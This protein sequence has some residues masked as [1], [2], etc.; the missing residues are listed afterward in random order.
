MEFSDFPWLSYLL[1]FPIIG[2]IWS[3]SFRNTPNAPRLVALCTTLF[4]LIISLV[5]FVKTGS[6]SGYSL[7]EEYVWAPEL[8]ISLLLGVDGLSSPLILLTGIIGPL[9][10]IFAWEEKERAGLFF[11]LLLVMQTALYGVF[12]TLDYFVFYVFWEIVLIPMFF[13]IAIWGGENRRYASIKFFIYT[14]TASVI[15][16]VG[17]MALYFE[18]GVQSFSMIDIAHSSRDFTEDF[19][20]WVFAA[21][22]IGF[23]VKIPSFPWHTWLPDAHVQAPT[24]GSILLAGVMLKMGLYGLIRAALP[25]LPLGAAYFVPLMVVLAIISILYGAAL[26]LGQTDLKKLVAYSSVSHMGVALLGVATMTELGLAGAVFMMFAHGILSPAMFMIA[27]VLLHQVGTREIPKLGGLARHQP[28]TTGIFV[29][30]FMGSLGLPGMAVFV[31]ELAVFIAFFQSH[32]YWLLL[33]I[34]GMVL[35]AGYHLW[36]LQRAVFGTDSKE[37]EM[38]KVH[39]APWYELYPMFTII[40]IAA[41]FGIFPHYLMDPINTACYDILRFMGVL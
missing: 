18:A 11:S 24:A 33:P 41:I 25:A 22:F 16:L 1:V 35:T 34:F 23:A 9:T 5:V 27:G 17:F 4:T 10:V 8:G 39:E 29:V 20:I 28:K 19:Q 14:F 3:I 32:G 30:I 15:M 37:I 40:I 7:M 36:A 38:G 6:K 21:L 26:S 2:A 13:L 31:A 12:V